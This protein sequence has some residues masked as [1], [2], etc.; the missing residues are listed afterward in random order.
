MYLQNIEHVFSTNNFIQPRQKCVFRKVLYL[1]RL[2]LERSDCTFFHI[3]YI[4][5]TNTE[6]PIL[7][8]HN[9]SK[10]HIIISINILVQ[11]F[12]TTYYILSFSLF[13]TEFNKWF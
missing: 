11:K 12:L 3:N 5:D 8:I 4:K 2:H 6:T 9:N 10:F 13:S 7:Q 1:W